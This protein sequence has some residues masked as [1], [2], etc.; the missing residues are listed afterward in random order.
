VR[1]LVTGLVLAAFVLSL[2]A[3]DPG[4]GELPSAAPASAGPMSSGGPAATVADAGAGTG[5]DTAAA[6][7]E[8]AAGDTAAGDTAAG[9][10][11]A[12]ALGMG[13]AGAPPPSSDVP[14]AG[15]GAASPRPRPR[16]SQE[17][18]AFGDRPLRYVALGDSYTEGARVRVQDNW[19]NQLVRALD[20]DVPMVV[21]AN[22]AAS[23]KT[24]QDVID[25][26]L[27]ELRSLD[28]E[29]V[30][31]QIGVNDVIAPDIGPEEYRAN[32]ALV[33]DALLAL[34]PPERIFVVTTPDYTRTPRGA[35]YGDPGVQ[36]AAIAEVNGILAEAASSRGIR[37]IDIA[38]ISDRVADDPSLLTA[39]GLHPSAKQFAGWVELIA[40]VV[41]EALTGE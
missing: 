39:D 31:L 3:C 26:Q 11:A 5:D 24:S 17:V 30:S 14:S 20:G 22:I 12:D 34:L 8:T 16:A 32:I 41:R 29:V 28:P 9:D 25:E 2:V 33:L 19:P 18:S 13:A 36:R 15:G 40:P 7:G 4:A 6:A 23:G 1:K 21:A 38:P 10:T 35:D 37:V 27:W